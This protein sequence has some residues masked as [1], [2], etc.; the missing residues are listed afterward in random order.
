MRRYGIRA[1]AGS[2]FRPCTTD[3]RHYLP[4]V[5]NLLKQKF[6]ASAAETCARTIVLSN[7]CTRCAVPLKLAS[8]AKTSSKTPALLSRPNRFQTLFHFPNRSGNARYGML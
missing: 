3:S 5:P 8:S 1:L 6:V 2:R 4:I 7:I